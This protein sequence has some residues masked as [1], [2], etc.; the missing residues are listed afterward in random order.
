MRGEAGAHVIYKI[1]EKSAV[2]A[3]DRVLGEPTLEGANSPSHGTASTR[4]FLSVN[5]A[6]RAF[7]RTPQLLAL[8]PLLTALAGC[9]DNDL[10]TPP[11]NHSPVINTLVAFPD[12]IG[13][14]DSTV[15]VCG[16]YDMDGDSLV[17][18][19]QTD[20]RLDIQGTPTWNKN[21]NNTRSPS[22][23]FYNANL[24]STHDSAWVYCH[25]RDP[26]GGGTG[27]RVYIILRP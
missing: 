7:L 4:R 2:F 19:W 5:K 21:L 25:V 15:V 17:Y 26:R 16:A 3:K 14:S 12:S 13:P 8:L 1:I 22:H 18:D 23:T 20:A 10:P 9:E 24:G 11:N 27:S 6:I